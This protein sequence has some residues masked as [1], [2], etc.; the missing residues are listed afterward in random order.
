MYG[1]YRNAG[2]VVQYP[3]L[4][5]DRPYMDLVRAR[6]YKDFREFVEKYDPYKYEDERFWA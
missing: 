3:R 1:A 4:L 5:Y 6:R 2:Y